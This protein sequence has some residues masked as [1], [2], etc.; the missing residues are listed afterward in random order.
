M[1]FHLEMRSEGKLTPAM[2]AWFRVLDITSRSCCIILN[3]YSPL[4]WVIASIDRK[5][6]LILLLHCHTCPLLFLRVVA[7]TIIMLEPILMK[8]IKQTSF[9]LLTLEI[10]ANALYD[11]FIYFSEELFFFPRIRLFW[12]CIQSTNAINRYKVLSQEPPHIIRYCQSR[13][14]R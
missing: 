3:N 5:T 9:L 2:S 10:N 12:Q 7:C 6:V 11:A 8:H 4:A 1:S 13:R 14:S